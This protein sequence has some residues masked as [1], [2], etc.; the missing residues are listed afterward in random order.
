MR[1][2]GISDL[3]MPDFFMHFSQ[4]IDAISRVTPD[5]FSSLSEVLSPEL[6]DTCL[7]QSGVATL[8]KRRLPLEM[9]VWSIVGMALFRH[10]PMGQVVN[11]LDIVLPGKRPFV[12]PSAVVQA[13]QRLGAEAVKR[14]FEQTQARWH[15]QTPHPHWCGL[16]LLAVDGVVWRTPDSPENQAAFARTRNAHREAS[17]PQVRMVCQMELTS[18]L[19]TGA[20]FD[21]V[22]TGEVALTADLVASTPDHSLT[23]F[24]RGFYSLGLLHAWQQAGEQRHWLIPLRKGTQYEEIDS[25]GRQD[26]LVR[27]T[28][29]P[30]ARAKWPNLPATLEARLM[31][32]KVKGKKV[33]VLTS[34][35]D[36]MR[37]PAADI[38]DLYSYRW[39][40]ELGYREMKQSLLGNRLTLRSRT[41]D[42]VRQE[43]W[44]TLLAYNLIRFQMA[45]MAYSLDSIHPNQLSF[46]QAA[47]WIIKELSMLPAVSPGRVPEVIK[48]MLEMAPSFV[49]PDRRE[50]SYPRA[51]RAHPQKYS[52]RKKPVS[53][54]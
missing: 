48:S 44:G 43:L 30:Q 26:R 53:L 38:V 18:H 49:L 11:Q 32:R 27:L 8:R 12:A 5:T 6:I 16:R 36:P 13:R 7:E 23:L 35:T 40:I 14:V 21:S 34:M 9:V 52:I 47:H 15:E 33:Q 37:F 3:L 1:Y 39:E 29:S 28:T 10:I 50:R 4:A 22:S 46:H 25:L 45:R 41:P 17:Y 24:D 2:S 54:N 51:V 31:T 20:A 19:V 42:M